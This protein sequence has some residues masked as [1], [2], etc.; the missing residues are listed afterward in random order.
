M[1]LFASDAGSPLG[2]AVLLAYGAAALAI[3]WAVRGVLDL[4]RFRRG[5]TL[6]TS[7][8]RY[9]WSCLALPLA[10]LIAL[11]AARTDAFL[12]FRVLLSSH[13]LAAAAADVG[14]SHGVDS[15]WKPRWVGLFRV[16]EA[17]SLAGGVRFITTECGF[18]DCG[19][20]YWMTGSPP[21]IGEDYYA[22][23]YG[24]WWRW[25]RSW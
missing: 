18:D 2:A 5:T 12:S 9:V 4:I 17:E 22:H 19:V 1:I 7:R 21:R 3:W 11:I 14:P 10:L 16:S 13:A 15:E 25:H 6:G 24:P 8:A 20:V 23:L